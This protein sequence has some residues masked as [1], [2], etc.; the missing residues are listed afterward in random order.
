MDELDIQDLLQGFSA[1]FDE[2]NHKKGLDEFGPSGVLR[3]EH[4]RYF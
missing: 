1:V 2:K 4:Y 3:V